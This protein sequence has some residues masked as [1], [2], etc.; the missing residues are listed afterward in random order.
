MDTSRRKEVDRVSRKKRSVI[1]VN[2]LDWVGNKIKFIKYY[3]K[4]NSEET[5]Q[6]QVQ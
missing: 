5:M 2:L 3:P 6:D 4:L 1:L